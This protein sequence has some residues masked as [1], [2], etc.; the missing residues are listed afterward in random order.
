[1]TGLAYGPYRYKYASGREGDWCVIG[2]G[3]QK[4]Y[5]ALYVC[6]TKNGKYLAEVYEKRLGKV[7]CGKSCIR[8]KKLDDLNLEVIEKFCAEAATLAKNSGNLLM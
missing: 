5:L 1:M 4:N 6:V 2:L 8:F 3:A 7:S